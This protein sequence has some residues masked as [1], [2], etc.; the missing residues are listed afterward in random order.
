MDSTR[1]MHTPWEEINIDNDVTW[2]PDKAD[3]YT[4]PDIGPSAGMS[5]KMAD[6]AKASNLLIGIFMAI[7]PLAFFVKV[8]NII[9][10]YCYNYWV[11]E[12]FGRGRDGDQNRKKYFSNV[13]TKKN[14][15][16]CPGRWHRADK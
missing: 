4:G 9:H 10:I 13:P 7:I 2:E 11:V 1:P 5:S 6:V 3:S 8:A 14:G 12:K 16:N 15:F